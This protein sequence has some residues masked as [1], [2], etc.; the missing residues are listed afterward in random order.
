[1][2]KYS[3]KHND[4][5]KNCKPSTKSF[6]QE[7]RQYNHYQGGISQYMSHFVFKE[8]F[9]IKRARPCIYTAL[10]YIRMQVRDK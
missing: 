10:T 2:V 3:T 5:I 1:M 9:L 7:L 6:I 4:N 8:P